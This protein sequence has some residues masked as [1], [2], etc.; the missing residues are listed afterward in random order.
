MYNAANKKAEIIQ[1]KAVEQGLVADTQE[2]EPKLRLNAAG[3]IRIRQKL[4]LTQ[5][6]FARLLDVSMHTVSAWEKGK[7][8]PRAGVKARI[9]ALRAIGKKQARALLNGGENAEELSGDAQ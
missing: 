4:K 7:C 9:C 1:K 5:S 2:I 3:I 6:D 8:S